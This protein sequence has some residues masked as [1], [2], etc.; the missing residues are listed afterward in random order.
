[1]MKHEVNFC[2][3][4]TPWPRSAASFYSELKERLRRQAEYIKQLEASIQ[5]SSTTA[6]SG[7]AGYST[8]A[9]GHSTAAAGHSTAAAATH[10]DSLAFADE[11]SQLLEKRRQLVKQFGVEQ[12]LLSTLMLRSVEDIYR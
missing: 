10:G 8:N 7:A 9:A 12:T 3:R 5:E 6:A 11:L 1:M 2:E 4:N